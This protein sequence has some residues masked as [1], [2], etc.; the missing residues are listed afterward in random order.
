MHSFYSLD[1]LS[2][3]LNIVGFINEVLSNFV[4]QEVNKIYKKNEQYM[5]II[6]ITL[7]KG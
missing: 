4:N 5:L 3:K 6:F 1:Y 2:R 7:R